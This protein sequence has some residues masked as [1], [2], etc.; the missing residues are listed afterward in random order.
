MCVKNMSFYSGLKV[1]F[2]KKGGTSGVHKTVLSE[3]SAPDHHINFAYNIKFRFKSRHHKSE[4]Y[5]WSTID[6]ILKF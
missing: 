3:I 4:K 1:C 2:I 5:F 6:E